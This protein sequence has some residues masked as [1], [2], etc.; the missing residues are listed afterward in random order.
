M[1]DEDRR[2][3]TVEHVPKGTG[4]RLDMAATLRDDD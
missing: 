1:Y 2:S 3:L 4:R